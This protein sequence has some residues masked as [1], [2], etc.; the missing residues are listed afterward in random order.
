MSDMELITL[1]AIGIPLAL[2]AVSRS[3][4]DKAAVSNGKAP[5]TPPVKGVPASVPSGGSIVASMPE[6]DYAAR[7]KI[8]LSAVLAG[9]EDPIVY[10]TVTMFGDGPLAGWE[11]DVPVMADGLKIEG[12]R[13]T[14][15]YEYGQYIADVLTSRHPDAGAV[16]MM[17]PWLDA[18]VF[19]QSDA[20]LTYTTSQQLK[21]KSVT[22]LTSQM[23]DASQT[24]DRK[25][26]KMV[27]DGIVNPAAFAPLVGNVGKNWNLSEKLLWP[28]V[29]PET[30]QL[31]VEA[32]INQGLYPQGKPFNPIQYRGAAHPRSH[33]DY[34]QGL[35]LAGAT[36]MLRAPGETTGTKVSTAAVLTNPD[37]GALLSGTKGVI[38]GKMV[39]EGPLPFDRHPM[40]PPL[41]GTA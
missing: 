2:A 26:S 15:S 9:K 19:E 13:M 35:R 31:Y 8:I 37:L 17:T 41:G 20:P 32:A 6:S 27:A 11:L 25:L 36:S 23:I 18:T 40:I 3:K 29:H 34:S 38:R 12:V 21:N 39:G 14:P 16:I 7:D 4:A 28:G 30:G 33:T 10:A 5:A 24:V 22:A 1:L